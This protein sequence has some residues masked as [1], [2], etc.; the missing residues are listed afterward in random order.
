MSSYKPF[1]HWSTSSKRAAPPLILEQPLVE[2]PSPEGNFNYTDPRIGGESL[3]KIYIKLVCQ[4]R[5]KGE[6]LDSSFFFEK[7]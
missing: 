5:G 3:S 6:L 7:A 4:Y 1:C 2:V